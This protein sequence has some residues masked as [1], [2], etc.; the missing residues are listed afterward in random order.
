MSYM[1]MY[2]CLV[3]QTPACGSSCDNIV[4]GGTF[5]PLLL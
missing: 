2:K 4:A 1:L 5:L 3:T